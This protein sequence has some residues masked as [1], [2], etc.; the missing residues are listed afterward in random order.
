MTYSIRSL[1]FGGVNCY[2]LRGDEGAILID[3]GWVFRRHHLDRAIRPA[4]DLQLI[5]LTHGD[6]DHVGGAVYLRDTYGTKIAMHRE[7]RDMVEHGDMTRNRGAHHGTRFVLK[8]MSL[9]L[10]YPTFTPNLY[11]DEGDSLAI[12]GIDAQVLHLPGHSKGSIGVLT[13]NGDL[14][15]GDLLNNSTRP[16]LHMTVDRAA[17]QASLERV[18][19]LPVQMIYPGHGKPFAPSAL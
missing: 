14:F 2:L 3:T 19:S 12:Y 11:L 16:Q 4:D 18:K 6:A 17:G 5:V 7:D 1:T 9:L 13:G 10:R 8:T 15:C